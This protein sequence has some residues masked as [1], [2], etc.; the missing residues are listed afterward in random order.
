MK[1]EDTFQVM[2]GNIEDLV[3]I[4]TLCGQEAVEI[5]LCI[6]FQKIMITF[7]E[8]MKF[9]KNANTGVNVE[10][11]VIDKDQKGRGVSSVNLGSNS[12]CP[13]VTSSAGHSVGGDTRVVKTEGVSRGSTT[14]KTFGELSGKRDIKKKMG[15]F[16]T[17]KLAQNN[18]FESPTIESTSKS[19]DKLK[20]LNQ[21]S[22]Y[23]NKQLKNKKVGGV[24]K[25]SVKPN[26][27]AVIE[28]KVTK[29][30]IK[31]DIFELNMETNMI[32]TDM[33][34][35]MI[36]PNV[37]QQT[38]LGPNVIEQNVAETNVLEPNVTEADVLEPNVTET[39]V[40]QPSVIGPTLISFDPS[41]PH[42][43]EVESNKQNPT[44]AEK[45]SLA[46]IRNYSS[47]INAKN[48]FLT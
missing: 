19:H 40:L 21:L 39:N 12:G 27:Q 44:Q 41:K 24:I 36:K 34:T 20:I 1:L 25:R 23:K 8:L 32:R 14:E 26:S 30:D 38:G 35:D 3:I 7:Q 4:N 42:G 18:G 15:K 37:M 47:V 2:T 31:P 48:H 11:N 9:D 43:S 46:W 5:D 22:F 28:N 17:P 16:M 13:V 6:F 33:I 29:H 45:I 10:Q